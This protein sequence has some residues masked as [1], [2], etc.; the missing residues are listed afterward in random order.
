[1]PLLASLL[2]SLFGSLATFLI[3]YFSKKVAI[4]L[5][6]VATLTAITAGL[7]LAMRG[8]IAGIAP[9]IGGGNFAVGVGIAIPPN[10]SACFTAIVACWTLCT[11]YTWKRKALT[12]F[13][14]A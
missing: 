2:V 13:A 10:A 4:G 9:I 6:M 5:A 11:L 14:Q 3:Q 12:I 1:M 7:L 8:L